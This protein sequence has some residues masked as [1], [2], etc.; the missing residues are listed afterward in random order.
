VDAGGR[1]LE[2]ER[3]IECPC[4]CEWEWDGECIDDEWIGDG[5]CRV[6]AEKWWNAEGG[7][8]AL[9]PEVLLLNAGDPA[10]GTGSYRMFELRAEL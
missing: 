4:I 5:V 3:A 7:G 9:P 8:F 1:D 6:T 10:S 2:R